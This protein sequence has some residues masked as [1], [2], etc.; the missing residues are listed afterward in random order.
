ML[1]LSDNQLGKV[2]V[3]PAAFRRLCVET[4]AFGINWTVRL[5]QPPSGGCVLKR[6]MQNARNLESTQPPSGGCVL[7]QPDENGISRKVFQPPSGGCVLKHVRF[8][9]HC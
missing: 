3:D 1:K 8:R 7:K 2:R 6:V 5:T 4:F 9:F